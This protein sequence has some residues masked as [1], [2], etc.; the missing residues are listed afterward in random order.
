V[1]TAS[2][3]ATPRKSKLPYM[4]A[5]VAGMIDVASQSLAPM[6]TVTRSMVRTDPTAASAF[7][8]SIPIRA[9]AIGDGLRGRQFSWDGLIRELTVHTRPNEAIV[10]FRRLCAAIP[11]QKDAEKIVVAY[12]D[13]GAFMAAGRRKLAYGRAAP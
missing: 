7:G 13:G 2:T 9:G 10:T 5:S 1:P 11:S 4:L 3:C 8:P 12:K 6:E